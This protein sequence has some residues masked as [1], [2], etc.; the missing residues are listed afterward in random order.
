MKSLGA[1]I[2]TASGVL[3]VTFAGL[4]L[5]GLLIVAIGLTLFVM[6]DR[7]L[8]L[9]GLDNLR[10]APPRNAVADPAK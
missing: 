6:E 1:A 9:L 7:V 5:F 2:I 8:T 4:G 10:S 3:N